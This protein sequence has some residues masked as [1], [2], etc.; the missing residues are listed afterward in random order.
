M[1]EFKKIS[2][3][4]Y[5]K[6]WEYSV[7]EYAN[8]LMNGENL[9]RETALKKAESEF[10]EMLYDGPDTEDHFV[11]TIR[12]VQ[13]GKEVGWIWYCY[14]TDEDEKQV[15]LCDFV[16]YEGDR[17]KGIRVWHGLFFCE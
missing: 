4:E 7:S 2:E 14:E 6:F 1:I 5:S 8:D 17:R 16:I 12:D 13:R 15:F 11:M 3:E 10:G 9:D